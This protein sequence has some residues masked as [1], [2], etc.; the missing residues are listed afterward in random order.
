MFTDVA[1]LLSNKSLFYLGTIMLSLSALFV[2]PP[3]EVA[4]QCRVVPDCDYCECVHGREL[5]CSCDNCTFE[6]E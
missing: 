1:A 5:I 2:S 4:A 6:C 3:T